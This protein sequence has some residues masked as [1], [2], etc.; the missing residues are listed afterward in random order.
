MDLIYPTLINGA[1][2]D[3]NR[4][5]PVWDRLFKRIGEKMKIALLLANGFEETEALLPLDFLRR[6]GADIDTIGIGGKEI[7]GAHGITIITEL[8]DRCAMPDAYDAVIFPGGMPGAIN[9]DSSEFTDKIIDAVFAKGGRLA[10][11][12]AAPLILG[13]RGLLRG[14]K[15]TCYPGFEKELLGA[16]VLSAGVVT[17]GLITTAKSAGHAVSLGLELVRL[18]CGEEKAQ[19]LEFLLMQM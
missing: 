4:N 17:D 1:V 16:E 13:R 15:A 6:A 19:K 12:C 18:L 3:L 2:F 10:A 7:T 11:I 14:K 9:L 8:C 5:S